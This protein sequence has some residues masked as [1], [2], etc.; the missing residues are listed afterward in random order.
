[1][2]EPGGRLC[3][4]VVHPLNSSGCFDGDLADSPFVIEGSYLERSY[5]EDNMVRDGLE[6]TFAS[7]HRPLQDYTEALAVAGLVIERLRE[8]A[9]PEDAIRRPHARRWQRLPVFLHVRALKP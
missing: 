7:E 9:M 8:P 4:A 6:I 5:Y 3:L 1:M 2:L